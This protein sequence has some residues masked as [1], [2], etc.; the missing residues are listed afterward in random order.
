VS[1]VLQRHS[2]RISLQ[3]KGGLI[4]L[5]K[6]RSDGVWNSQTGGWT[7]R[8]LA[9]STQT[10]LAQGGPSDLSPL[11]SDGSSYG[12]AGGWTSW[13]AAKDALGRVGKQTTRGNQE[14]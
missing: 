6:L 8:A 12:Q 14:I 4:S 11:R 9:K 10:K 2:M 5:S 7:S 1:I 13:E 3:A